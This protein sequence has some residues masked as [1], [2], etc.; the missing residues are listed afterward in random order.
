MLNKIIIM[1][2]LTRDPEIRQFSRDDK[3]G[4]VANFTL[5]VDRDY[6]NADG[7]RETD[8]FDIV[9]WHQKADFVA[10]YFSKG[11][12]MCVEGRLQRDNWTD[13]DNNPRTSYKIM[14]D[15][16]YFASS[17]QPPES[18]EID[19]SPIKNPQRSVRK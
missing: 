14:A 16:V 18:E 7:E 10:E 2:R 5:A 6:K 8:F 4:V 12:L 15:N 1:G 3:P 19:D 17:K 11:Q 9:T 13:K